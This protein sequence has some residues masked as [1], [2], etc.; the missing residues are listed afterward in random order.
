MIFIVMISDKCGENLQ[1]LN[2]KKIYIFLVFFY[3]IW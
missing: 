2:L 1:V 3:K